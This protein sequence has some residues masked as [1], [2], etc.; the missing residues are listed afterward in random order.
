MTEQ[1][2][3]DAAVRVV[4][5][6]QLRRYD[7][8]FDASH[9]SWV[10]FEPSAREDI[11]AL[12][13]AGLLAPAEA[14]PAR[15]DVYVYLSDTPVRHTSTGFT[16]RINVDQGE[17]WQ[18]VGVE[19][20]G[21]VKVTIDGRTV[22]PVPETPEDLVEAVARE[23]CNVGRDHDLW[24]TDEVGESTRE[25]LRAEARAAIVAMQQ[26]GGINPA[27]QDV[28]LSTAELAAVEARFKAAQSRPP[29]LLGPSITRAQVEK[30]AAAVHD[31]DCGGPFT[32]MHHDDHWKAWVGQ[33]EYA[34]AQAGIRVQDGD[35]NG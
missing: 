13:A 34:L 10:D 4:A 23:I 6:N 25:D 22:L 33:V 14:E 15:G 29:T 31:V 9:L 3:R 12:S 32:G 30:M 16:D 8:E 5:E 1:S 17:N 18:P 27:V 11:E 21:A 35:G 28:R 26:P 7:S 20:L 2:K 24:A 19:V